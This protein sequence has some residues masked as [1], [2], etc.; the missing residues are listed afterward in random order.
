MNGSCRSDNSCLKFLD[1][2]VSFSEVLLK[3]ALT[4]YFMLKH[5]ISAIVSYARIWMTCLVIELL[6]QNDIFLFQRSI[7]I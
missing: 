7:L 5:D 3:P 6:N 4:S 2:T 1:E